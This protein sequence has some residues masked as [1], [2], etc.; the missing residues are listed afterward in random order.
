MRDYAEKN[1][2]RKT[3]WAATGAAVLFVV[4]STAWFAYQLVEELAK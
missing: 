1:Y 3:N 4:L 2:H